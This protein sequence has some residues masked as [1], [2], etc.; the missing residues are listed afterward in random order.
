MIFSSVFSL[1]NNIIIDI[2]SYYL[3]LF[4]NFKI[5]WKTGSNSFKKSKKSK[6]GKKVKKS[7]WINKLFYCYFNCF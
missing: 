7:L 1:S 6:K 5:S 3:I 4:K 2:V